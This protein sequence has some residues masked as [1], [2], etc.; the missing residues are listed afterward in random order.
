MAIALSVLLQF[1]NSDYLF[2]I[3]KSFYMKTPAIIRKY[4]RHK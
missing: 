4:R 1:K 2:V 3:Y